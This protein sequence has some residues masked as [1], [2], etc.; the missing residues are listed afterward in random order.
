MTSARARLYI[1]KIIVSAKEADMKFCKKGT[2]RLFIITVFY[3]CY[4]GRK[5]DPLISNAFLCG[6]FKLRLLQ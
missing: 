6:R 3:V 5:L 1:E 4:P 2:P